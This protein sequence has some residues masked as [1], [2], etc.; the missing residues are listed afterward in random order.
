MSGVE[1]QGAMARPSKLTPETQATS[2]AGIRA[3]AFNW[4]AA[5]SAGVAP[6]TF[7]R[8]M[9]EGEQADSGPSRE[10]HDT[11]CEAR[12]SARVTAEQ[13]VFEDNPLAWLRYGPGRERDGES[14]WTES[15]KNALSNQS[16]ATHTVA[17]LTLD[18]GP[19]DDDAQS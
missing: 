8:W 6:T 14:G 18:M 16:E 4:V 5:Q 19:D 3:G 9:D 12:A 11:V 2:V 13:R 17:V 15:V 1:R 10:F 7:Y